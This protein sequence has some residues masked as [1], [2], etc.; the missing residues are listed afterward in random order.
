MWFLSGYLL[1]KNNKQIGHRSPS[2]GRVREL[3]AGL[4]VELL[5]VAGRVAGLAAGRVAG[6]AAGRVAGPAAERVAGLAPA[7]V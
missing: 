5:P 7:R 4:L 3:L 1:G 2:A 6:P